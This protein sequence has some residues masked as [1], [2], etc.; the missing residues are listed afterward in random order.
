MISYFHCVYTITN[1]VL[2]PTNYFIGHAVASADVCPFGFLCLVLLAGVTG[3]EFPIGFL[4][5]GYGFGR[6]LDNGVVLSPVAL[7]RLLPAHSFPLAFR[8]L[9]GLVAQTAKLW[10]FWEERMPQLVLRHS[11]DG[12]GKSVA[13]HSIEGEVVQSL[14]DLLVFR[15]TC[16]QS[17][18]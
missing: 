5:A 3:T 7:Y 9:H 11:L 4:L 2:H 1:T 17:A 12:F 15:F 16:R 14:V 8:P 13:G 10:R 6:A 18:E